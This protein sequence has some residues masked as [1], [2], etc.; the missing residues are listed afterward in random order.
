MSF[1][2]SM[3]DD[4]WS[5]RL[6]QLAK[7]VAQ[8]SKDPSSKHGAVIVDE[9]R[10]VLATGYNGFARGVVDD[11]ARYE[12]RFIKYKMIVHAEANAVLSAMA[13]VRGGIMVCTGH[14]CVGCAPLIIQAGIREVVCPPL[15]P[16]R[17]EGDW[18]EDA[19]NIAAPML[20]EAGV[21]VTLLESDD[22][23]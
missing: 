2:I 7:H 12:E 21:L 11:P 18:M 3:L 20:D 9:R 15:G 8:W 22:G 1:K 6:H 10:V 5:R 4:K 14:P 19:A 23:R 13:P 16:P 17:F